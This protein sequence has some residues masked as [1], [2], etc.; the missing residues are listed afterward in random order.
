MAEELRL[1]GIRTRLVPDRPLSRALQGA[2]LALLG[3]DAVL[4]DGSLVHK[5]GTRD[6]CRAAVRRGLPVVSLAPRSRQAQV[7]SRRVQ[8]PALFDLTPAS[9][10]S[11]YWTDVGA[12]PP[13]RFPRG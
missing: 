5:V 4:S 7:A 10:I 6:L 13:R 11:A 1:S 2:T 9:L 8:P 12:R 3:A